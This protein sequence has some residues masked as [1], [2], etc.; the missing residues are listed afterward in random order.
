M[1]QAVSSSSDPNSNP[2]STLSLSQERNPKPR[3]GRRERDPISSTSSS[4]NST[5]TDSNIS[6]STLIPS[7]TTFPELISST[8]PTTFQEE[9][10]VNDLDP[11]HLQAAS[12]SLE[13]KDS[14]DYYS[15]S[16]ELEEPNYKILNPLD[17]TSKEQ[18]GLDRSSS[19]GSDSLTY[20][21]SIHASTSDSITS[22]SHSNSNSSDF[23]P[24]RIQR[25]SSTKSRRNGVGGLDRI[26]SLKRSAVKQNPTSSSSGSSSSTS[27]HS[28]S[29]H[30][31]GVK[32]KKLASANGNETDV[33]GTDSS[34]ARSSSWATNST[35]PT[36]PDD[37]QQV[38]NIPV[39]G[40]KLSRSALETMMARDR[41]EEEEQEIV[42]T[43]PES[44]ESVW[45]DSL[46]VE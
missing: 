18:V 44:V 34:L 26:N 3:T 46:S 32:S 45:G 13:R 6:I 2:N 20:S 19:L 1:V 30:N 43:R 33:T 22:H 14:S 4:S 24:S 23:P 8:S 25:N 12:A 10:E 37:Y 16:M 38:V 40:E 42:G 7:S 39:G 31:H 9:E 29:G 21:S 5:D 41:K 11:D 28:H 36:S 15:P 35:S 27:N 17:N